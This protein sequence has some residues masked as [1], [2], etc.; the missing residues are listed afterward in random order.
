M[1]REMDSRSSARRSTAW[2]MRSLTVLMRVL[3]GAVNDA[4][5]AARENYITGT[6]RSAGLA[7]VAHTETRRRLRLR[8]LRIETEARYRRRL[9]TP[10]VQTEAGRCRRQRTLRVEAET[11]RRRGWRRRAANPERGHAR[12]LIR[13]FA[14]ADAGHR[15][16]LRRRPG[17]PETRDGD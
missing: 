4:A 17:A 10:G 14:D 15:R 1:L 16:G 2:P 13:P 12:G 3:P 6:E 5:G 11:G 9:R 8:A 7:G